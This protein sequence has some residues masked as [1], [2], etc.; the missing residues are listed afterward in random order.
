MFRLLLSPLAGFVLLLPVQASNIIV[1]PQENS[2]NTTGYIYSP[3]PFSQIG[4]FAVDPLAFEAVFHPNGQK[5]YVFSKSLTKSIAVHSGSAPYAETTS[6][7]LANIS[8]AKISPDGRRLV[9][10][11]QAVRIYDTATDQE[12]TGINTCGNTLCTPLDL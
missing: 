2:G 4:T 9:V 10:L 1:L 5:F 6:R 11:S 3:E 12:I 8:T 7:S